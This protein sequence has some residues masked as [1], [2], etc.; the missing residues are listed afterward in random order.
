MRKVKLILFS[1]LCLF[2]LVC[3]INAKCEDEGLNNWAMN[4]TI[5]YE[6]DNGYTD[7]EGNIIREKEFLYLL[8][9]SHKKAL[10]K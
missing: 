6:E 4:A 5:K 10:K 3:N 1:A 9:L 2:F 8:H 7:S